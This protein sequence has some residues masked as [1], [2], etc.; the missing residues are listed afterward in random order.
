MQEAEV[1]RPKETMAAEVHSGCPREFPG[2]LNHR[3]CIDS[4]SPTTWTAER[5]CKSKLCNRT[6]HAMTGV[7]RSGLRFGFL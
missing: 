1:R 3:H 7:K 2:R 6:E 4:S 5:V